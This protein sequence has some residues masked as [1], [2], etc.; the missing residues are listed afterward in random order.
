MFRYPTVAVVLFLAAGCEHSGS[1]DA[2][3][4]PKSAESVPAPAPASEEAA[5]PVPEA[6]AAPAASAPA[7]TDAGVRDVPG[8]PKYPV[9]QT[10]GGPKWTGREDRARIKPKAMPS[11]S[12]TA[13]DAAPAPVPVKPAS[14]K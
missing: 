10:R 4:T 11:R 12:A 1:F 5:P 3:T 8:P 14:P 13:S 2:P 7:A 6:A 9:L